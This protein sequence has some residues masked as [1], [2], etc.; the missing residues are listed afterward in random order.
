MGLVHLSGQNFPTESFIVPTADL[1][2]FGVHAPHV[3]IKKLNFIIEWT[4][5]VGE[6]TKTGDLSSYFL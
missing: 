3:R 1:S 6:V 2:A 4:P 5:Q